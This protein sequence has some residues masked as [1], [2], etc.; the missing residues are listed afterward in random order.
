MP[1]YRAIA[2]LRG[3]LRTGATHGVNVSIGDT[4]VHI[5]IRTLIQYR[6][7]GWT[8]EGLRLLLEFKADHIEQ[9]LGIAETSLDFALPLIAISANADVPSFRLE[10]IADFTPDTGESELIRFGFEPQPEVKLHK[11]YANHLQSVFSSIARADEKTRE[12]VARALWWYWRG[13]AEPDLLNRFSS[14]W[15]GLETLNPRL[16]ELWELEPEVKYCRHCGSEIGR[17]SDSY[18]LSKLL[19]EIPEGGGRL[20]KKS[21]RLRNEILHGYKG[22]DS[23]RQTASE[24]MQAMEAAIPRGIARLFGLERQTENSLARSP[25]RPQ[26]PFTEVFHMKYRSPTVAAGIEQFYP[27]AEVKVYPRVSFSERGEP[28][29]V[30]FCARVQLVGIDSSDVITATTNVKGRSGEQIE[31]VI[32]S[33]E[34]REHGELPETR[35]KGVALWERSAEEVWDAGRMA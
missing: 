32:E 19:E 9:A 31:A 24:V 28:T 2:T 20:S 12:R 6:E 1:D 14:L 4:P 7:D 16:E 8:Y 10:Q 35:G 23:T 13:M 27:H 15:I 26:P 22:F 25:L 30:A 21:K 29:H 17:R 3:P 34:T 11:V 33:I 18:G 5:A